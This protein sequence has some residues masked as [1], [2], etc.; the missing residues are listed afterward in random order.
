MKFN[1]SDNILYLIV[2]SLVLILDRLPLFFKNYIY[3]SIYKLIS[4]CIVFCW[5]VQ[6]NKIHFYVVSLDNYLRNNIY[7]VI[8]CKWYYKNVHFYFPLF[9][10]FYIDIYNSIQFFWRIAIFYLQ[11]LN[12][13]PLKICYA[14]GLRLHINFLMKDQKINTIFVV[15]STVSG[16]KIRYLLKSFIDFRK[17]LKSK[18]KKY[19]F[20]R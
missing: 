20:S 2:I 10:H 18:Y 5:T 3:L 1:I 15:N 16:K 19:C 9:E 7:L 13:R 12:L 11:S 6:I 17:Y 14:D 8:L 4:C